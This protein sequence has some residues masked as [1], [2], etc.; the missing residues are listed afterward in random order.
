MSKQYRLCVSD[1]ETISVEDMLSAATAVYRTHTT[2]P[3]NDEFPLLMA[4]EVGSRTYYL[5]RA[6]C[7]KETLE[8]CGG[9]SIPVEFCDDIMLPEVSI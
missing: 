3:N 9:K 6:D 5:D 2:D 4:V 1:E 8:L 7:I